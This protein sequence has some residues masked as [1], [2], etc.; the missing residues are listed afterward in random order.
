MRAGS[1]INQRTAAARRRHAARTG[2]RLL[3][4]AAIAAGALLAVQQGAAAAGTGALPPVTDYATYPAALPDG[5][6]DGP[7]ALVG[8]RFSSSTGAEANDL[9]QLPVTAGAQVTMSW[10]SFAPGCTGPDGTPL[11]SVSMAVH[12]AESA[13]FDPTVDQPLLPGWTSCGGQAGACTQ[14]GGR[15]QLS[16]TVPP[17]AVACAAQLEAVLGAPLAVV[18]PSGSFYSALLRG[19][20]RPTMLISATNYVITPCQPEVAPTTI[21]APTTTMAPTTTAPP[22][23]V[24]PSSTVTTIGAAVSPESIEVSQ[25]SAVLPIT[26]RS[27]RTTTMVGFGL[28]FSGFGLLLVTSRPVVA[29]VR[30]PGQTRRLHP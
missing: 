9:R 16:V 3:A 12:L 19:D 30:R 24:A 15:F 13:T 21:V 22:A 20:D 25:E 6:P 14:V 17:I 2:A 28:L 8:T 11:V 1:I 4:A 7:G 10:S 18:G 5:C 29:L 23:T 27:T 26:G